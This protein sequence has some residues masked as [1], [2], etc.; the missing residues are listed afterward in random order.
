MAAAIAVMRASGRVM[1]ERVISC[2]FFGRPPFA[3]VC[4]RD[5]MAAKPR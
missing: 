1:V 2:S 4:P 3:V 5:G